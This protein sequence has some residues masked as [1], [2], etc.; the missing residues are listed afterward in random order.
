MKNFRQKIKRAQVLHGEV[1][2][3]IWDIFYR[4][5][6]IKGILFSGPDHWYINDDHISFHG[7]DGCMGCYDPMS[8]CIPMEFFIEEDAFD[9][10][11]AEIK[12]A[13]DK[14]KEI[15]RKSELALM[16]RLKKKYEG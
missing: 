11:E 16:K 13:D 8:M 1:D 6:K 10:L 2:S 3:Y 9:K 12:A 7:E 14:Q 15:V 5:K 4:Y